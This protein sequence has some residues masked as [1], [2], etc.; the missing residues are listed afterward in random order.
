MSDISERIAQLSPAKRALLALELES[1]IDAIERLKAEPIA[2]IGIGCRFPGGANDPK[3]F[4]RLLCEGVDAIT[5]VP[6][7]RWN[8]HDFYDAELSTPGKMSTRWGG[9]LEQVDQFDPYTFGISAHEAERMDPQ[10]RLL[11]EVAWEALEDGGV[12]PQRLRQTKTGVFVG[13]STNDYGRL[14]MSDPLLVDAYAG[15]GNSFSIAA[16]RLSYFFD[17]RGPSM[18]VDT[19]CSSSL[20][21]VHLACQSLRN[22]EATMALAGGVSVIL[23]PE[24]TIALT[25]AGLMAP[26]GRCKPF[27]ARANGYVRS[28]GAGLVVLKPLTQALADKDHIYAVIRGSAINQ[29]GRSNG[30]TAPNRQA[31]EAVL[32]EAYRNAGVSPGQIQYVETHGTG[33]ALGDPIE[34][35]ALGAV[36]SLDRPPEQPCAIGSVKSNIGH[37][38]AAAGIASL[39]KV[40]L[41]LKHR[42][43]PPSLH[44]KQPNSYIPFDELPLRVQQSLEPWPPI[45]ELG[46]AGASSFGFGGTNSH[47]VLEEAPP[48]EDSAATR[49]WQLLVLSAK[50]DFA[51]RAV[52]TNM[53][54]YLKQRPEA[55]LADVAYTLKVGRNLFNHRRTIV[56]E[57]LEDAVASLETLNLERVSSAVEETSDRPVVFVFPDAGDYYVGMARELYQHEPTF[58]QTVDCCCDLLTPHLGFDLRTVLY[59]DESEPAEEAVTSRDPELQETS[60]ENRNE[61]AG[62]IQSSGQAVLSQASVFVIEYALA[63]LL[64]EWG[65]RPQSMISFGIGEYVAACLA[66]VFTLEDALKLV[67][68]T[69]RII[70]EQPSE[71]ALTTPVQMIDSVPS[72]TMKPVFD[73]FA[74]VLKTVKLSKPQIPYLSIATGAWIRGEEAS[75]SEYWMEHMCGTGRYAGRIKEARQ[76]TQGCVL[77]EIGS[78]QTLSGYVKQCHENGSTAEQT[79]LSC[80]RHFSDPQS[81][82]AFLLKVLGKLWLAGVNVDWSGFYAHEQRRKLALP[83]YPFERQRYWFEVKSSGQNSITANGVTGDEK[84]RLASWFY[85]PGWKRTMPLVKTRSDISD[86]QAPWLAFID[87]VGFCSLVVA[88]LKREGKKVITVRAGSHFAKTGEDEYSINPNQPSDYDYLTADLDKIPERIIHFWSLTSDDGAGVGEDYLA[89]CQGLGFYSLLFLTKAVIKRDSTHPIRLFVVS[90]NVHRVTGMETLS[91]EKAT[92]L[93]PCKVIPQEHQNFTC[94]NIDLTLP[95]SGTWQEQKLIDDLAAEFAAKSPDQIVAYRGADRW[96]QI[97]EQIQLAEVDEETTKLRPRGVYLITGGLGGVGLTIAK[98]L[99]EHVQ[100]RL[101]LMGRTGLPERAKWEEWLAAH[102]ERDSTSQKIKEVQALEVTGAEVMILRADVASEAQMENVITKT[103]ERFGKLHGV[104]H[105]AGIASDD[106]A[107]RPI[108]VIGRAECEWHF[109]PKVHGL[110]VLEKVLEG[111]NLDFCLLTSSLVS[112]LGGLGVVGYAAA[113]SFM[114][115]FAHKHNQSQPVSWM[116][117]SWDAWQLKKGPQDVGGKSVSGPGMLPEEGVKAF[118][119]VISRSAAAQIVISTVNLQSRINRRVELEAQREARESRKTEPTLRAR[120]SLSTDYVAPTSGLE[121]TIAQIWQELLGVDRIGVHDNFFELG[122]DSLLA[123]QLFNQLRG[124][125]LVELPLRS[126]FETPTVAELAAA[127]ANGRMSKSVTPLPPIVPDTENRHQPFPLTDM[128]QAYWVGR[129]DSVELGN[130][131]CHVYEE[132]DAVGLNLERLNHAWQRMIERHEMLR[133]TILPDGQQQILEQVPL[134]EIEAQ[135]LRGLDPQVVATQLEIVRQRMSHQV[136][137]VDQ[138]PLFE[139][140]ASLLDDERIRLHISVD[141]MIAD[142]WSL[143][144]LFHELAQLYQNPAASLPPI[145]LSFRDYVLAEAALQNSEIYE[146]SLQYWRSRLRTLPPAPELPL[147]KNTSSLTHPRFVRRSEMLDS[148]SWIRLKMRAAQAGLT[149]TAVVL[150]AYAEILTLWSKNTKFTINVPRFNR[151]PLHPQVNDIVGEFASF[152][153]LE[154]DN[155]EQNSFEARAR[156]IQEQL[157]EDMNHSYVSGIRVLRELARARAGGPRVATTVVFTSTVGLDS[158]GQEAPQLA[159]LNLLGDVVYSI[160]Q[161]PQVVLDHQIFDQDGTLAF[162]WDAVEDLFPEGLIDDMFGSY[163]RFLKQLA[164]DEETW[165]ATTR[166]LIPLT[167]LEQR[168]RINATAEPVSDELLHTMF[169]A[170]VPRRSSQAAVITSDRILTYAELYRLSTQI[171]HWLR[172]MGALP[173]SLVAVVMEK[174]WEQIAAVLGVMQSG[175]AYLPIDPNLPQERI[176]YLL[177]NGQVKLVLTQPRVDDKLN[178]PLTGIQRLLVDDEHLVGMSDQPLEAS[179]TP[180]DLAYVLFTSGSTGL[181]KGAMITQRG[182]VN[183][184]AYTNRRFAIGPEDRV[185]ALTALHHDMSVFDIFGSLAAGGTIVMPEPGATRD[186]AR[187]AEL[188]LS[189]RVTIWNSVPA[190]LTMLVEYADGRPEVLPQTLRLAFVGGDWIPL[191]LP[192]QL[193]SLVEGVQMVSVGGPTETTLWNILYPVEGVDPAWKSIPYGRPI[194]NTRYHVLNKALEPCPVWVAG[195]LYI[196]GVGLAQ[197]YWRDEEKTSAAFFAHPRTGERLYRS[198]DL[199]RFLPDG[200]IEFIGREDFQVKIRGHRIELGEIEAALQTHPLIH[201][202]VVTAIGEGQEKKRLVGYVVARQGSTLTVDDLRSF[203]K[204]KLSDHMVPS[205]FVILDALPLTP[206]GKVDRACLPHPQ[207]PSTADAHQKAATVTTELAVEITEVIATVLE[208]DHIDP[209]ADLLSLGANSLHIVRIAN[210]LEKRYGLRPEINQ[211]FTLPTVSALAQYYEDQLLHGQILRAASYQPDAGG[212]FEEGEV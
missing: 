8:L 126:L 77:L 4:W 137:H 88:R 199:G 139:I 189:E 14:Q 174:G 21:A 59:P 142:A 46:L 74:R 145:E 206:N 154:V 107:F 84:S 196:G 115:A 52:T 38:E 198:G 118:E 212:E 166:Q 98:Y 131:A 160:T 158:L 207:E 140:R 116:S 156:Q 151:L 43:I 20:V 62:A 73:S 32:R 117:V 33:T 13:I 48:I 133:M 208:V 54:D 53:A 72:K 12:A 205:D 111:H 146:R 5:E 68:E 28:E 155:S 93:G 119:R 23:S 123:T 95:E 9:F 136:M 45:Y 25:K 69:A 149:P 112:I 159:A 144:L 176:N 56:C 143:R 125:A 3:A 184:I 76:E 187:W 172:Q 114:D 190:L 60:G 204:G 109:Q 171:G 183:A 47:V 34:A 148:E 169:T 40:A 2:I 29:D 35:Y 180:D 58:R 86:E 78:G 211:L 18:A 10:Q 178:W 157:W 102:H 94:R 50:T 44:F 168:A 186:P 57:K 192:D 80:L 75:T 104:I 105:A 85:L 203:L 64:M 39:I 99:A 11:L 79:T 188:M 103:C 66:G 124:T 27:D 16:N 167:Q 138:W 164:E 153:L 130:V 82:V 55:P 49:P 181:P 83:T 91:P 89:S 135:D 100:A 71:S 175:A 36:L 122:G 150:A 51:L 128:Q 185:L 65:I 120:P 132:I 15:T 202:G 63:Q 152:T 22:G 67:A 209:G 147:A 173:N 30:L 165:Q 127:V 24:N 41:A 141:T 194:A 42:E 179:Q 161:T 101:V 92:L 121:Q 177:E 37:L 90:N 201:A 110:W 87:D 97:F 170:Q 19:A 81:D 195:Q 31:Q 61:H 163:C 70:Q 191:G 17:L 162:V 1:K 200:N 108:Q 96:V 106:S 26:D 6:A 182:A 129:S 210:S 113:N 134:Y 193:K 7:G 197:G